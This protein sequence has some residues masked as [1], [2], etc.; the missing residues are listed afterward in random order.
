[1]NLAET[2]DFAAEYAAEGKFIHMS[3]SDIDGA[4][5]AVPHYQLALALERME[6]DP[7]ILRFVT[8]WLRQRSFRIRLRT[9]AGMFFSKPHPITRGLPQVGVLSPLFWLVLFNVIQS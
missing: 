9:A 6:I 1:M 2:F 7:H 3:S 4:F 8:L 5:D